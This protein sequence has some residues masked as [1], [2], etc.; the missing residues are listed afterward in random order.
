M[1]VKEKVDQ[2]KGSVKESVG[3]LTGDKKQKK[4]ELLK[5]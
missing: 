2:V 5:K 4:K 3:K 1:S